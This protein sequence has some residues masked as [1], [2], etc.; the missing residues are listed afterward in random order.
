MAVFCKLLVP[1][2]V[3]VLVRRRPRHRFLVSIQN[4]DGKAKPYQIRQFLNFVEWYNLQTGDE[5]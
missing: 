2:N 1:R 5:S 3:V 4:V